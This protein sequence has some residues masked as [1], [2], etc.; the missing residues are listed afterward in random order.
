MNNWISGRGGPPPSFT[1]ISS[2]DLGNGPAHMVDSPG[3]PA[4]LR[5]PVTNLDGTVNLAV[6]VGT[7]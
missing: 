3:N 1:N 2:S 4:W 7:R 5:F 6:D